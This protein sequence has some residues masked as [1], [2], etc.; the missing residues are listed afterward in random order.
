MKVTIPG[1]PVELGGTL[2]RS[3][4]SPNA[5]MLS[6]PFVGSDLS[7]M[8][9]GSAFGAVARIARL[10]DLTPSALTTLFG[11]RT[12]RVDDLSSVMTFSEARQ[13]SFARALHLPA[14]PAEWN[15]STWFPF[16][17]PSTLLMEGWTFRFCPDC[18]TGG[19]HTLFQQLP[20]IQRCPWHGEPLRTECVGCGLPAAVRADWSA[21]ANLQCACG[22]NPLDT[23]TALTTMTAPDGAV[24]LVRDYLH[25]AATER[26]RS[27]LV[28]PEHPND[29]RA[30][31]AAL[32]KLP[33][34][35]R[36]WAVLPDARVHARTACATRHGP[37]PDRE[38]LVRLE[39]LRNDRPGF[40][41]TPVRLVSTMSAVAARLA[42]QLP[43]RSLTDREMS[44][45]L[46]GAGLEAP[47]AFAPAR[48]SF[49]GEVSLLPPAQIGGQ[50]FLNLTCVHPG[51]Y[52][53]VV[54]LVDTVLDGR[55]LFDFH[56]QATPGEF[57]LLLRV[58]GQLLARGYS[59]GLRST[60][61][62]HVPELYEM[63]REAPHLTKPWLLVRRDAGRLTAIR[64]AW[65]PL[66]CSERGEATV[67]QAADDANRR[68]QRLRPGVRGR[69]GRK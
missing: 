62:A 13:V 44:L 2:A 25:W 14:V 60:L 42:Q 6:A 28:A 34:Q 65:T 49:S 7:A 29:P 68:R 9:A 23:E 50:Q 5:E 10:N 24:D 15:L 31:L 1:R 45:F 36:A 40:L 20:W 12:R 53:A 11:V 61:A 8:P 69:A 35:W 38:G 56:A 47:Q 3:Q 58:S 33:A 46:A 66:P 32:V 55:T 27:N 17:A 48:R 37:A 39:V 30:A 4:L 67:L 64:A 22:R 18:L 63:R 52:R 43:P 41:V 54:G 26:A 19:Y 59:Q 21:S 57:D 51:A 16:K